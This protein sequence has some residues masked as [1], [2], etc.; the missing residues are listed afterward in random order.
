MRVAVPW[1]GGVDSSYLIYKNLM[2]GNEVHAVSVR[3]NN[4]PDQRDREQSSRKI[5][6]E[7]FKK[8]FPDK[9]FE[10]DIGNEILVYG[11]INMVLSQPPLWVLFCHYGL[12][13]S[14]VDEI[15]FGY[16]MN[17]DAISYLSDVENL[18]KSYSPF[19]YGKQ[20]KLVFPLIK[21]KKYQI[22]DKLP[23]FIMD[24]ISFCEMY[25]NTNC[26]CESCKRHKFELS[27]S[28][29]RMT[30]PAKKLSM[31]EL[32]S[33]IDTQITDSEVSH[34]LEIEFDYSKN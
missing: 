24:N 6:S 33:V 34:Q 26:S 32:G 10:S 15:H 25:N 22:M 20:P 8:E 31:S 23:K 5:I 12:N 11:G 18:Y 30:T 2:D 28:S 17:D 1:S 14:Y 9:F 4:N 16:I 13:L 21:M 19:T 29:H 27:L 7:W 3:L